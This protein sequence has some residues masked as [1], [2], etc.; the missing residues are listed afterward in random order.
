M[1]NQP[2]I[3]QYDAGVYQIETVDAVDGGV[4]SVTNRPLLSLSNRTA[5]LKKHVDDIESGTYLVD[6]Y[7]PK[8]SP[9]LTGIPTAPTQAAGD[10]STKLATTAFVQRA[11][12]GFVA[13][14]VSGSANIVLNQQQYGCA[15]IFL[16]G[17]L[18]GNIS[19]IFPAASGVWMIYNSSTGNFSITCK[20]ASGAGTVVSSGA[21][22][23]IFCDGSNVGLQQTDFISPVL[24]GTPTA[25]TAAQG[26]DSNQIATMSAILQALAAV[27]FRDSG[28]PVVGDLNTVVKTSIV[29][30][31][32]GTINGPAGYGSGSM[33]ITAAFSVST[34]IQLA[35]S[36]P[37]DAM[38]YRR[39]ISGSWTPWKSLAFE[40][41]PSL[42]GIPTAP[43]AAAATNNTQIATTAFVQAQKASPAFTGTP[44]AP[45]APQFATGQQIV[46]AEALKAFGVQ[47]ST[48]RGIDLSVANISLTVADVGSLIVFTG[49][50][51]GRLTLPKANTV[52]AGGAITIRANNTSVSTN[53]VAA[54][55][56]DILT[57][58]LQTTAPAGTLRSGD[59]VTVV[60]DGV[61]S[62]HITADATFNFATQ[63][64]ARW[65]G[66][67]Q[68]VSDNGYQKLP[69]DSGIILQWGSAP[70]TATSSVVTFPTAFPSKCLYIGTHDQGPTGQASLSMFQAAGI[71]RTGFTAVNIGTLSRG[72]T[73]FNAV[74]AAGRPWF[75]IGV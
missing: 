15:M 6:A 51:G 32:S 36:R 72:V 8:A 55:S 46:N 56:G 66:M 57:G 24:T 23:L 44:T 64:V 65:F 31:S 4:G 60:S 18:T 35:M 1:A 30:M 28:T 14:N 49:S 47:F 41:S 43:T 13:V 37:S 5:W 42:T 61:S 2:E 21:S 58:A 53:V 75:A 33:V 71:S 45:T 74:T 3:V 29:G 48:V 68:S 59:S 62:W 20:T 22:S 27:G 40:D 10:N 52:P 12:N 54:A 70:S 38:H 67:N 16:T 69:G 50:G 7:A 11:T 34:C 26:T 63:A 17:A 25:P 9:A 39:F 73:T 19:I